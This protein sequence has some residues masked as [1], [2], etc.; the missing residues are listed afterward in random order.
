MALSDGKRVRPV[1]YTHRVVAHCRR[2]HVVRAIAFVLMLWLGL[3]Y[4]TA[5]ACCGAE[6]P[7]GAAQGCWVA[8]S[9]NSAPIEHQEADTCFCCALVVGPVVV[10]VPAPQQAVVLIPDFFVP[11]HPGILPALYHP[12][13][14][15]S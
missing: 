5:G 14:F 4:A 3:D 2:P 15:L 10:H 13:Q 6:R 7:R 12:P 8:D 1:G 9:R 11:D